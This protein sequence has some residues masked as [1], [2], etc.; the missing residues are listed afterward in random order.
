MLN[1]I[2]KIKQIGLYSITLEQPKEL[3]DCE[4]S[5]NLHLPSFDL[6][7]V[8]NAYNGNKVSVLIGVFNSIDALK[9]SKSKKNF[10]DKLTFLKGI[11]E[12]DKRQYESDID[13]ISE[14]SVL[15]VHKEGTLNFQSF[16]EKKEG[17]ILYLEIKPL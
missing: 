1:I 17:K 10:Y 11:I 9:N 7:D 4:L 13:I 15:L 6:F 16:L 5:K 3:N 8:L 12:T 14:Y 2:S